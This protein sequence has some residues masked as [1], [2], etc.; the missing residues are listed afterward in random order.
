MISEFIGRQEELKKFEAALDA[1]AEDKPRIAFVYDVAEKAEDKGGIGKTRLLNEFLRIAKSPKYQNTFLV[2]DEIFDFFE[3]V[4]RDSL[5]RISHLVQLLEERT[6]TKFFDGFWKNVKEYYSQKASIEKVLQ[7]YFASYNQLCHMAGKK[8]I[9]FYDTFEVAE[10]TLNYF[11][12][13]FRFIDDQILVNSFVVISGRNKP[14]LKAPIWEE[15]ESQIL[16][17]PLKG[18]SDEEAKNYFISVGYQGLSAQHIIELNQKARGRPI[19]LALIVD[20]LNNIFKVE[21][22]LKLEEKD[23]KEQLVAFINDFDNPPIGQAIL[24]M[25]HLKHRCNAK[26]LRHFIEPNEDFDKNFEVLKSLSFVRPL[27]N[28]GNYIVLHDEMQK[29]VSTFILDKVYGEGSLRREISERAISFYDEEIKRLREQEAKYI[30]KNDVPNQEIVHDE[31]IILGAEQ[32]YHKLYA[33]KAQNIDYYFSELYDPSVEEGQLDYCFILL[34]H[35]ED[36]EKLLDLPARSKGRIKM[37][38]ARLNTEKFLVSGNQYYYDEANKLFDELINDAK[39]RGGNIYL[40]TV[41]CDYGTLQFYYR[42]LAS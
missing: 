1:F 9:H 36:L 25:T 34:G 20:Y 27:G 7:E 33:S 21:D 40:G 6:Q 30:E 26:F 22:I 15:R 19:L 12:L 35:L 17:F 28:R 5:S 11:Q 2:I 4:Y 8:I 16:E 23:F 39:K 18:F 32:W 24:A 13:P 38:A 3:P 41:L 29:M 10:K 31:R 14:D 42:Q 37:R